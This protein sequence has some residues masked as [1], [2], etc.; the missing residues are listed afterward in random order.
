VYWLSEC[1]KYVGIKL[2]DV[3]EYGEKDKEKSSTYIFFDIR[4]Q[5]R[6]QGLRIDYQIGHWLVDI[7]YYN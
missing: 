7:L 2:Q 4:N 5:N 3:W 1:Q 6:P